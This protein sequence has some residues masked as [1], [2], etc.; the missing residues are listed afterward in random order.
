M[1]RDYCSSNFRDENTI[2]VFLKDK[3]NN[4]P[5]LIKKIQIELEIKKN[6]I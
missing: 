5:D 6:K 4:Y 3:N 1:E 2:L